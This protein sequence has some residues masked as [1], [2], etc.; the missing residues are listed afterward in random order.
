MN[1]DTTTKKKRQ[2]RNKLRAARKNY[3]YKKNHYIRRKIP[4]YDFLSED[5]LESIEHHAELLLEEI[6]IDFQQDE[7]ALNLWKEAGANVKGERVFIPK[8]L[9]LSLIKKAPKE[10]KQYARNSE[11]SVMVGGDNTVFAP[12][13]GP[14]FISDLDNGR[15]YATMSDFTN[16]AKLAHMSPAIHHSGWLM[17]EPTDVPVNKRH[18]DMMNS[19]IQHSDLPYLGPSNHPDYARD[20]IEMSRIVFGDNFMSDHAVIMGMVTSTSPLV[21]DAKAIGCIK[22]YARSNQAIIV[23]SAI[24][25][26]SMGPVTSVGCLVETLAENLAGMSFAQL[27]NPGTPVVFGSWT[28][29][30]SMQTGTPTFGMPETAHRQ[31]ATAQL[32]RRLGLPTRTGGSFC[33]SKVPDA[34]AAYESTRDLYSAVISG[35]NFIFN[36]AG[37]L[38]SGLV[39]SYEKFVMDTDQLAILQIMLEGMDTT[40]NGF[41]MDAFR[42][43]GPGGHF[44]SCGHTQRNFQSSIY[45]STFADNSSYEQWQKE[46]EHDAV[47]RA[48][49]VWKRMLNEYEQPLLDQS[50]S[51]ELNEY[52]KK[53]KDSLPDGI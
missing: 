48:N 45:Q 12:V 27:V 42:E 46:G 50:L 3:S 47:S 4:V 52:V 11:R 20:C 39:A 23:C 34:Q 1:Q 31:F 2:S 37:W 13:G 19:L 24:L 18:L 33:A 51:E 21:F 5:L 35:G 22:E 41:A 29:T 40:D 10:F 16:F 32:G 17:C 14:A 44:L 30:I 53:M 26:G 7:E 43:I 36:S 25:S 49:K 9:A 28:G 8:G 38:E 6:G 15:R